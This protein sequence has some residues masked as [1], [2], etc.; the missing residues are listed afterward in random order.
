M[1]II[2]LDPE[3]KKVGLGM[4][5][6]VADP[7]L[8][9][10]INYPSGSTATGKVTRLADFGAFVEL[11]PG[12]EGLVHVSEIDYKRVQHVSDVLKTDQQ[13]TVKVLEVDPDKRRVSLSIKALLA[14]PEGKKGPSDVDLAPGQGEVYERK[15]KGPLKGGTGS[16][17][18]SLFGNPNDF[19]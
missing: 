10:S 8:A 9:V 15:H 18:S 1:Q 4:R 2:S 12:V 19:G 16:G 6:L 3:K 5:Q 13:V 7:W 17:S 11:E 14:R